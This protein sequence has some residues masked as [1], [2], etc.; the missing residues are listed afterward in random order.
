MKNK[1]YFIQ[2]TADV[3]KK[4]YPISFISLYNKEQIAVINYIQALREAIKENKK[5]E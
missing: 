1:K 4:L 2:L 3:Y 5:G